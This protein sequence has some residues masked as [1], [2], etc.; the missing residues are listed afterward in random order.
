MIMNVKQ[1]TLGFGVLLA[2]LSHSGLVL[3]AG[4]SWSTEYQLPQEDSG[5]CLEQPVSVAVDH[6]NQRYY[7]VDAAKG[8][9][10]SFDKTGG[11]LA[12]FNAGGEL[13]R[14]VAVAKTS[15]GSLWVIE[16]SIN[17]LL[18]INPKQQKVRKIA[19]KYPDGTEMFLSRLA[20]DRQDRLF[21]LDRL[22]GAV[23]L[24]DDSLEI[25]QV[26]AGGSTTHGFVDF[27]L[28]QGKLWA[29]D[30]LDHT[31]YRFDLSGTVTK[32]LKLS[33]LEFPTAFEVD[34]AG[35]FYLLDRH[36]GTVVVYGMNGMR[37]YDFLGKGKWSGQLWNATDLL[38]DWEGRL[39][40][41]DE[42]NGR[43]EVLTR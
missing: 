1:I 31:L 37:S 15:G 28:Q 42:G 12:A 23:L 8:Q 39:C 35:S 3:A 18:Y 29:L 7:V 30:A 36:A 43:V 14:P 41:V 21:V 24:L 33:G 5:V 6:Q 11:F 10:V 9:L 27:K 38:F 32:K 16:R 40:V 17:K 25:S 4:G 2:I 26:Y 22:K 34:N 13:Q 20:L 19:P